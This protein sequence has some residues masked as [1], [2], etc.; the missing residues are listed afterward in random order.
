MTYLSE[1]KEILERTKNSP[2]NT[3]D[4]TEMFI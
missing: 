2:E 4:L 3:E 1:D